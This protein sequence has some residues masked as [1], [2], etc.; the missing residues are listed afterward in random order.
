MVTSDV[1]PESSTA[2]STFTEHARF[3]P[4]ELVSSGFEQRT[5]RGGT[6]KHLHRARAHPPAP[7]AAV[8]LT[9][10]AADVPV[11]VG[12]TASDGDGVV[13]EYDPRRNR[14]RIVAIVDGVRRRLRSRRV[15]GRT[16]HRLAFVLC[17]NQVTGVVDSGRGW[18]PLVTARPEV[19]ELFDLRDPETLGRLSYTWGT[20]GPGSVILR[21]IVAGVFGMTGVRDPHLVQ[22]ADGT[23][24]VRDGKLLVTMTCAG[25]GFFTQ[26]H[27]GVFELDLDRPGEMRQTGH[28]FG[29]RGGL[30]LGDHAGQIIVDGDECFVVVSSWGDFNPTRGV[31]VRHVTTGLEILD[32]IHMLATERLDVPTLHSAWDPSLTRVDGRWHLA[33]V[34]SPSQAPFRFRPA[35]A[36]GPEGASYDHGLTLVG[37]DTAHE[38]CEGPIITRLGDDWRLLTSDGHAREYPVYDLQMRRL[39]EFDAPYGSNIP[40]PQLI[41]NLDI[42]GEWM[43][44]FDGTPW[45]ERVLGYGTHGDVVL[46][47]RRAEA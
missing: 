30:L 21:D 35:L 36:A 43:L 40:H 45:G 25:M 46:M 37:A 29:R 13:V 2:I 3:R 6:Y 44:T 42:G 24:Y 10:E 39:G 27:W 23:P 41:G 7:Y 47:R 4:F 12:L 11:T 31:H 19:A 28:L 14:V 5:D 16:L 1:A 9:V 8:E 22:H 20:K 38:Q 33:Y 17:E 18:R 26:A 32:G 34:E 15:R